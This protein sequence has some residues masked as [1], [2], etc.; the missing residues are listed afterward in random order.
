MV[1]YEKAYVKQK[2]TNR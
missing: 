1:W 2:Y